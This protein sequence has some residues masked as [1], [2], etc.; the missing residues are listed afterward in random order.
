MKKIALIIRGKHSETHRPALWNQHAD[1]ILSDGSPA[2]FFA[3]DAFMGSGSSG[4][5][6]DG[7]VF[8]YFDY[9]MRRKQYVDAG[10]AR[11][12]GLVSTVCTLEVD[13]YTAQKFDYFW[14]NLQREAQ[15]G[16]QSFWIAGKNCSTRAAQAFKYAGAMKGDIKGIDTPNRLFETLRLHHGSTLVCESGYVGIERHLGDFKINIEAP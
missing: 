15:A 14:R 9:A 16:E 13:D 2:G 4:M 3:R 7:M 5:F 12:R 11:E 1:V 8:D 6:L 10:V